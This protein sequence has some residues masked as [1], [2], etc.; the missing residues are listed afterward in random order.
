MCLHPRQ[1]KYDHIIFYDINNHM[2][3]NNN[4]S[5]INLTYN[6]KTLFNNAKQQKQGWESSG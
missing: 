1:Q 6:K 4:T 2:A 5:Q 3:P